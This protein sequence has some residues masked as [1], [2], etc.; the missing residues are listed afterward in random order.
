[1]CGKWSASYLFTR[2]RCQLTRGG[3]SWNSQQPNIRF[4]ITLSLTF[5]GRP[6]LCASRL[7]AN[8]QRRHH[9][10]LKGLPDVFAHAAIA[11]TPFGKNKWLSCAA[12][13]CQRSDNRRHA[14]TSHV[15]NCHLGL[16]YSPP[17]T[18]YIMAPSFDADRR[19][20]KRIFSLLVVQSTPSFRFYIQAYDFGAAPELTP[21]D[22]YDLANTSVRRWKWLLRHYDKALKTFAS[23]Q[24]A[25]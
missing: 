8:H 17:T 21:P 4:A 16:G 2:S 10:L 1:M 22:P 19:R 3:F 11:S 13:C 18:R 7:D 9:L 6:Y 15:R 14:S 12:R 20:Q 24:N 5:T 25:W 23:E